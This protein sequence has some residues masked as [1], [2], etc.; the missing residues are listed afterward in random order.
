MLDGWPPG[1]PAGCLV[2]WL[3]NWLASC[4]RVWVGRWDERVGD[5]GTD[6]RAGVGWLG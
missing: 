4:A 5:G 2:G 6:G 1:W 3:A